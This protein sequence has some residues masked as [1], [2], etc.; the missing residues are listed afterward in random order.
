[1]K[2]GSR[3][4]GPA[5]FV[6]TILYDRLTKIRRHLGFAHSFN[7]LDPSVTQRDLVFHAPPLD[8]RLLA[9]IK[10]ISPQFALRADENSRRFWEL[11]QN[12]A[13]WGE[14]DAIA[15]FLGRL[16]SVRTVL[17]LG[18]GLGRSVV[19]FAKQCGWPEAQFDLYES[20]GPSTRYTKAGSRFSDS[21]CGDLEALQRVLDFN[22][23]GNATIHDAAELDCRLDRLPGPYDLIYSFFAIGFHWSIEHFLDEILSL[24]HERSL[25]VFSL[26]VSFEDLSVLDGVPHRVID[27]RP[28]WPRN[29]WGQLLLVSRDED[30]L[31]F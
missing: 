30:L 4:I 24:M 27:N 23:I 16:G 17:D 10:L 22:D 31:R 6:R 2:A 25:G 7:E 14:Y 12:G 3:A 28:S 15:P 13:C 18:P 29:R 19:F 5:D 21:F 1:M 11:N 9:A 26:H 20:D 8:D